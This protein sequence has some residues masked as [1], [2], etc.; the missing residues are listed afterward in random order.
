M[1]SYSRV[2]FY[3]HFDGCVEQVPRSEKLGRGTVG[4]ERE[5]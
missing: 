1:E 2:L 3:T 5:R 4:R